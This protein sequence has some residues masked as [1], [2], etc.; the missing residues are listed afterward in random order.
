MSP[1]VTVPQGSLG[2]LQ[3]VLSDEK[4]SAADEDQVEIFLRYDPTRARCVGPSLC[5][6]VASRRLI[7]HLQ[8]RPRGGA[9]ARG[10]YFGRVQFF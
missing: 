3:L 2:V 9:R 5:Y 1:W 8:V 4:F 7:A 6:A 10:V